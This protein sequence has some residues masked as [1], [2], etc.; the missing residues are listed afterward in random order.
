MHAHERARPL[1]KKRKKKKPLMVPF[2]AAAS[3]GLILKRTYSAPHQWKCSL[4]SSL[5]QSPSLILYDQSGGGGIPGR[6]G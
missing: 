1:G 5:E 2:D 4:F 6:N 3:S